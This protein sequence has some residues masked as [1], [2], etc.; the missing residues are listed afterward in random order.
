MMQDKIDQLEVVAD[1]ETMETD[2]TIVIAMNN[3]M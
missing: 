3:E 2:S 1:R